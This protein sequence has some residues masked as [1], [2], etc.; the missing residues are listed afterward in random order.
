MRQPYLS[1]LLVIAM[2]SGLVSCGS[3][4]TTKEVLTVDTTA[5]THDSIKAVYS[6]KVDMVISDIPFP[7]E[8][9]EELHSTHITFDQKVM[10][11]VSNNSK[12][13]QYNSKALNLGVYGADLAYVVTYEQ[14]QQ[15]GAY[16]K[17]AKKL[18]DDLNIP[19]GF[20]QGMMDKYNKFKD[21]KDSLTQVVYDSYNEVDRSLK[22]DER[23]G[24]AAL[25]VTGSWLEGLYL[26]TRTFV[27]ADKSPENANLYKTIGDQKQSLGIVVKLLSEYKSDAY[28]AN[29]IEEL[30]G[31]TSVYD[32]VTD[33][34]QMNERQLIFINQKVEKL[35]NKIVEG[36]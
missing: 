14:F 8:I 17:N 33:N 11:P 36:L 35:R 18:A 4:N 29:L 6:G 25:V 26:S 27:N 34:A 12:Y 16:V 22:G 19:F 15:I 7:F 23:V 1:F 10:N 24:I 2:I 9:L 3:D 13:N 32:K 28:I 21:N 30:K 31:I 5:V 20:N